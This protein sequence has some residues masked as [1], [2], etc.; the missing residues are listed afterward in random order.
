MIRNFFIGMSF[1]GILFL[2]FYTLYDKK[3]VYLA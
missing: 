1:L 3:K 2:A